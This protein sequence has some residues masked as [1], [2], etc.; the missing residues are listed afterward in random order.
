MSIHLCFPALSQ[1]YFSQ[2]HPCHTPGHTAI[3]ALTFFR[4]PPSTVGHSSVGHSTASHSSSSAATHS[5]ILTNATTSTQLTQYSDSPCPSD[6]LTLPPPAHVHLRVASLPGSR[7]ASYAG[8]ASSSATNGSSELKKPISVARSQSSIS[9]PSTLRKPSPTIHQRSRTSTNAD[10]WNPLWAHTLSA[11]ASIPPIPK[12]LPSAIPSK[13]PSTNQSPFGPAEIPRFSRK[14]IRESGVVMPVSAKEW[15]RRQSIAV[16]SAGVAFSGAGPR[17]DKGKGK[18]REIPYLPRQRVSFVDGVG[19]RGLSTSQQPPQSSPVE[20]K[21]HPPS[22]VS[23]S[24]PPETALISPTQTPDTALTTP[25]ETHTLSPKSSTTSFASCTSSASPPSSASPT[26]S[27]FVLPPSPAPSSVLVSTDT[28]GDEKSQ[29]QVPPAQPR[30]RKRRQST[31]QSGAGS[32]LSFVD[33]MMRLS[34]GSIASF[35]TATSGTSD[36]NSDVSGDEKRNTARECGDGE[37]EPDVLLRARSLDGLPTPTLRSPSTALVISP[38]RGERTE[39]S[40]DAE[41]VGV[42]VTRNGNSN[43]SVDPTASVNDA[44]A[45]PANSKGN[46][47][48]S[49]EC[50]STEEINR[51]HKESMPVQEHVQL[52]PPHPQEQ[53]RK[54][55]LIK[56]RPASMHSS[57]VPA[58]PS[59]TPPPQPAMPSSIASPLPS[60]HESSPAAHNALKHAP[61]VLSPIIEDGSSHGHSGGASSQ[62]H[63]HEQERVKASPVEKRMV[64]DTFTAPQTGRTKKDA[65]V[66]KVVSP[67]NATA[68]PIKERTSPTKASTDSQSSTKPDG[69]RTHSKRYSFR[70][71]SLLFRKSKNGQVRDRE[72]V[73]SPHITSETCIKSG[74]GSVGD[75]TEKIRKKRGVEGMVVPTPPIP[76]EVEVTNASVL[77]ANSNL[78]RL[79]LGNSEVT[80][81]SHTPYSPPSPSPSSFLVLSSHSS[82]IGPGSTPS[83]PTRNSRSTPAVNDIKN[84]DVKSDNVKTGV[85]MKVHADSAAVAKKAN[86]CLAHQRSHGHLFVDKGA[87]PNASGA[88]VAEAGKLHPTSASASLVPSRPGT[89]SSTLTTSSDTASFS[90]VPSMHFPNPWDALLAELAQGASGASI[91]HPCPMCGRPGPKMSPLSLAQH[92]VPLPPS[93]PVPVRSRSAGDVVLRSAGTAPPIPS[94]PLQM[95]HPRAQTWAPAAHTNDVVAPPPPLPYFQPPASPSPT[96][97][98]KPSP[99]KLKRPQTAP[100]APRSKKSADGRGAMAN[101]NASASVVHLAPLPKAEK[102]SR[103]RGII[104]GWLG[105]TA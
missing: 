69:S 5:S 28:S 76:E 97:T 9:V 56:A 98:P 40:R 39:S 32:R 2:F 85:E 103:M 11:A 62:G 31:P 23:P 27:T 53:Q 100:N 30:P 60:T 68:S 55:K 77:V 58:M 20:V 79:P 37:G 104:K 61:T 70:L 33:A 50:Q 71:P 45:I 14:T 105:I 64:E 10:N 91:H 3:S 1:F 29:P 25:Q 38:V 84:V 26:R 47:G 59:S 94:S 95:M 88:V 51:D 4:R 6:S 13:A 43:A 78:G 54:R 8:T 24:H 66:A 63:S 42:P 12:V 15:R 36:G 82:A 65:A 81:V 72:S 80:L 16:P 52:R 48:I 74:V 83:S 44:P 17:I 93:L 7:P 102:E 21:V 96:L 87:A 18:E 86:L 92:P 73:E 67:T 49:G 101:V 99:R 22:P 34:V 41:A 46:E 57:S 89:S 19:S 90:T 35:I 75:S